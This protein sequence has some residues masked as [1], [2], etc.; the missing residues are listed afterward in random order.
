[1]SDIKYEAKLRL[2]DRQYLAVL[3]NDLVIVTTDK[4]GEPI[5]YAIFKKGGANVDRQNKIYGSG[6]SLR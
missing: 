1:M 2:N 3:S 4:N 5:R 6:K